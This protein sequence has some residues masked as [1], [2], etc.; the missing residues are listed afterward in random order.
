ML[1][2]NARK[3][4]LF[5]TLL[6]L[7][8]SLLLILASS[9]FILL[10]RAT[11]VASIANTTST[12]ST[13]RQTALSATRVNQTATSGAIVSQPQAVKLSGW[14]EQHAPTLGQ[15]PESSDKFEQ[16]HLF[17]YKRT[18]ETRAGGRKWA[19]R[20]EGGESALAPTAQPQ[21]SAKINIILDRNNFA[22]RSRCSR[23]LVYVRI[24][25]RT[26]LYS[27]GAKQ[28]KPAGSDDS[29]PLRDS[30]RMKLLSFVFT[31]ERLSSATGST[32]VGQ[33]PDGQQQQQD[34]PVRLRSN[35]TQLYI[36]FNTRSSKL[37]AQVSMKSIYRFVRAGVQ[38]CRR[39]RLPV[40]ID[41]SIWLGVSYSCKLGCR[42]SWC[43]RVHVNREA[44]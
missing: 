6:L 22:L 27:I 15:P 25:K 18:L 30:A 4:F 19:V 16:Q 39:R 3:W 35:L 20:P 14:P 31:L 32:K 36:C 26:K 38:V 2:A 7:L 34:K 10:K 8:P 11:S 43:A 42:P 29:E 21:P 44:G 13:S 24:N 40:S 17:H 33:E 37:E 9:A 5:L 1:L 28:F 23:N 41:R 12:S